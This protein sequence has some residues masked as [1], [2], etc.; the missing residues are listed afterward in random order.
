MPNMYFACLETRPSNRVICDSSSDVVLR[1]LF[2][3]GKVRRLSQGLMSNVVSAL[4]YMVKHK[5][6]SGGC[7]GS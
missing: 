4:A 3:K 5:S 6:A 2:T 7:L 1:Y